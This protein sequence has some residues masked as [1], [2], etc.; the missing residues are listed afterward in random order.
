VETLKLNLM[1]LLEVSFQLPITNPTWIFFLM[2]L[3][4][5]FAPIVLQRL[6]IP[7]IIGMILA[8]VIVGKYGLNILEQDDSFKIFGKVG[9]L[10]IMFLA[11]LEMDIRGFI[12]NKTKGLVFGLLTFAIPFIAA[13]YTSVYWLGYGVVGSILLSCIIADHTPITYPLVSN[14]G[15]G[16]HPSVSISIGG[17]L[18]AVVLS[19]FTLATIT[20]H[21]YEEKDTLFWILFGVKCIAYCAFTIFVYPRITRYFFRKYSDSISQYIFI[22]ALLFLSSALAEL[23]GLEDILGAFIAGIILNRY[24]PHVSPLMNRIE[25]VGNALFIPYFLV[26]VGMIIDMRMLFTGGKTLAVV[27][28]ILF[29]ATFSKWIAAF[30]TQKI[31]RMKAAERKIM[32]GLS[33]A[34]A[35]GALAMVMIGTKTLIAPNTYMMNSDELNGIVMLILGSCLI[36]SVFTQVGAKQLLIQKK[37]ATPTPEKE[38]PEKM[39]ISLS[40]PETADHLVNLALLMRNEQLRRPLVGVHIL[41]DQASLQYEQIKDKYVVEHAIKVAAGADVKMYANNRVSTNTAS[42]IIN[43][44]KENNCSELII[45]LHER[46]NIIDSMLGGITRNLLR[47]THKQLMILRAQLPIN[48]VRKL[49][50]TAPKDAELEAGFYKWV[51][52]VMRMAE[53]LDCKI[54]YFANPT[55][56]QILKEYTTIKYPKV[57]TTYSLHQGN[58]CL[59]I[60]IDRINYDHLL[61]AVAARPNSISFQEGMEK[62]PA[63]IQRHFKHCSS[64]IIFPD[65]YGESVT[66]FTDPRFNDEHQPLAG[67]SGWLQKQLKN[68]E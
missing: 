25:F 52:R 60:L 58:N 27:G 36:S 57:R 17:T 1:P 65:Q 19:L 41:N 22:L 21:Y 48:T 43:T 62:W 56:L 37:K 26:G 9:I 49:I 2:L 63:M 55:T 64:L 33:N 31:F 30:I 61:I 4:I 35:A 6:H 45:G 13:Y 34:H 44:L 16:K 3:I 67:F 18:V 10:Y 29:V 20:G 7:H 40:N 24:I 46:A 8:G 66:T 53:H 15:L 38:D 47:N 28:I 23:I 32:F 54:E 68:K 39:L 11:G 50:V 59:D 51:D 5:L 14:M 12:Q 42:S